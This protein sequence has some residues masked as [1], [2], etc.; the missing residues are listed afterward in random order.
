MEE[1]E[2]V[3]VEVVVIVLEAGPPVIVMGILL[4]TGPPVMV[5]LPPVLMGLTTEIGVAT[6]VPVVK[7]PKLLVLAPFP[8]IK[9]LEVSITE[10]PPIETIVESPLE[11]PLMDP[12]I[13]LELVGPP[14]TLIP[15]VVLVLV[16]VEAMEVEVIRI[17]RFTIL[18]A[19]WPAASLARTLST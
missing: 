10:F 3:L 11:E 6:M 12:P 15:E 7:E 17:P 9:L 18:S 16:E 2:P 19:I 5:M 8:I 14:E 1:V 4:V 13:I